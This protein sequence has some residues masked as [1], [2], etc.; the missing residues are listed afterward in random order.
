M[1]AF[2]D[3]LAAAMS[4]RPIGRERARE[5]MTLLVSGEA[6][7]VQM[8]AFLGALATR[9]VLFEELVGFAEA[10]R[11]LGVKVE[12]KRRPIVDTCG[13]GGD[14]LHTLNVSTAA[15][16]VAAGAKAAVAKHGNRSV[17]SR[18]GSADVIEALGVPLDLTPLAAASAIDK[19]GFAFLFAPRYHPAL[20]GV[21][22][23]RRALGVRTV[24]N[25][26]G[27][28]VNPAGATCQVV[29]VYA[30]ALLEP[31]ARALISLGAERALVL[32][33]EDGMDEL[34]LSCSTRICRIEAGGKPKFE[35]VAP[36]A[37]GFKRR[38]PGALRGGDAAQNAQKLEAVLLGEEGPLFDAAAFN[39]AAALQV[40]GLAKGWKESAAMASDSLRS[41]GALRVLEALRELKKDEGGKRA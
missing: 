9:E 28:L 20:A 10:L 33:A 7:E 25:A 3:L 12:P 27:P 4:G 24:F 38:G 8:S 6:N 2:K 16:F 39:A 17:S 11:G 36:E 5:A 30:E 19:F 34:S 37:A 26:L 21:A 13:T 18:C 35:T 22:G 1:S 32:R 41:L 14:G 31:M 15:A 23:V 40:A 29:G